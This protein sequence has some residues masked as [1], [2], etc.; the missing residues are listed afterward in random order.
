MKMPGL[1]S[2][3]T[4]ILFGYVSLTAAQED[5]TSPSTSNNNL[6]WRRTQT[7]IPRQDT[8]HGLLVSDLLIDPTMSYSG[9]NFVAQDHND[10]YFVDKEARDGGI[11]RAM[12]LLKP[13]MVEKKKVREEPQPLPMEGPPRA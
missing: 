13:D 2:S 12:R 1:A 4:A 8:R 9:G 11:L 3:A 7:S 10:I 6:R 5:P